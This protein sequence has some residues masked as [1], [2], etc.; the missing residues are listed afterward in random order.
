MREIPKHVLL[1]L[2]SD[3]GVGIWSVEPDVNTTFVKKAISTLSS[4]QLRKE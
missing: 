1:I 3:I 4:Y 2:F